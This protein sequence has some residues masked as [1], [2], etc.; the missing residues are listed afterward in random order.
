MLANADGKV[1]VGQRLDA[2]RLGTGETAWQMPQGG[3]DEGEKPR[4]AALRS[5]RRRSASVPTW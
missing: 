1:W 4:A 3:I 5:S 2:M